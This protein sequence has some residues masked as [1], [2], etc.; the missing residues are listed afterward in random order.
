MHDDEITL[1][2]TKVNHIG[3]LCDIVKVF[4]KYGIMDTLDHAIKSRYCMPMIE[5]KVKVT[6]II[7]EVEN[8]RF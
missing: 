3:P 4:H 7:I 1:Y 6:N 8:E 5:F 2:Y